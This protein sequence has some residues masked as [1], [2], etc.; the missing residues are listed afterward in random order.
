[1][2]KIF[3]MKRFIFIGA[4]CYLVFFA[5]LFHINNKLP[6]IASG[7][8][9]ALE[10]PSGR[11]SWE[12]NRIKDPATN[13][14]PEGIFVKELE[15]ASKLPSDRFEMKRSESWICRGPWHVGG[16][17][18]ALAYDIN[19]EN[20]LIAGAVSGGIWRS[21]NEGS[22][23][24]KITPLGGLQSVSCISQDKRAG[25]TNTWYYG[26]G[27]LYGNSA[28]SSYA[29]Y[30]G[31]GIYKSTDNGLSWHSLT[32]TA[33][34]TPTTFDIWDGVWNIAIDQSKDTQD[35]VYA[36]TY[37]TIFRSVDGG[38]SWKAVLGGISSAYSYFTDVAVTTK[39]VVYATLSYDGYN[40]GI[41]RSAD[42]LK[43]T[44]ITPDSFPPDY[45][46][47]VIGIDPN[48]E[49][50]VYFIAH[51]PDHGKMSQNYK[52]T[53]DWN[54][55]WKFTYISG[56]SST[57]KGSWQNLTNNIPS[58]GN[59][60]FDDFS[61]QGSYDLLV[62][63]KPGDS[64]TI[65]IG[66][67]NLYRSTDAF[68]TSANIVQIGGYEPATVL[69]EWHVYANH[70]PDQHVVQFFKSNPDV[71][72]SGNDGGIFKTSNCMAAIVSWQPLNHGYLT[73]Q[74]YTVNIDRFSNND[75]VVAGF[76]DN[77]NYFINDPDPTK[78]W[79][80]P[81]NGDGS[82]SGIAADRSYYIL[83]KQEG[84]MQKCS[85]DANGNKTAFA[86]IDPIGGYGYQFINPFIIDPNDDNLMYLAAGR[87]IFRNDKMRTIPLAGNYDSISY[88]WTMFT[89]S[90]KNIRE[91]TALA[92]SKNPANRLYFGTNSKDIYRIDQANTG[93]P[94]LI[95]LPSTYLPTGGNV[96]CI[97]VDPQNA[98]KVLVVYSNYNVYSLFYSTD[99]GN[100][101]QKT[102]GNLEEKSDGTGNGPS[103]RWVSVM[104]YGSKTLYLL[105][106]SV[107]L[108]ATDSL[109]GLNTT[110][111]QIGANSIGN[112]I[113]DMIVCR[114]TDGTIGLATHGSGIFTT[115][116]TSVDDFLGISDKQESKNGGIRIFPNPASSF[117]NI[118]VPQY[119]KTG[120]T[121]RILN[122]T[123]VEIGSYKS[124]SSKFTA[125]LSSYPAG[126]YNICIQAGTKKENLELIIVR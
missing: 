49:D 66:G 3:G 42:G 104:H 126:V 91:I 100:S 106:S 48:N 71:M 117:V 103:L 50:R 99:G 15:F 23:W 115:K 120:F 64:N 20:I 74:A 73:T 60:S 30:M 113:V 11:M 13:R 59:K 97:T 93:N 63:V 89:D 7:S 98:D 121:I 124:V 28:S 16:R 29:F 68:K 78:T 82:Y 33:S 95:K 8:E 116:I 4:L 40:K 53:K 67:T 12:F 114:E 85:L 110:W 61:A 57:L 111:K 9:E 86:R 38:T 1:M 47:I 46:R 96:S 5:L 52:G 22:S 34:N 17:T 62:V 112:A 105:G 75:I 2:F 94:A 92:V 43:W 24:S 81:L 26:T 108:F 84:K 72:L 58:K 88:G 69:P 122:L 55:L 39:G 41:W 45:K 32:A 118:E 21:V 54:S 107:G 36:A 80:M 44:E 6:I 25:K 119:S 65:I 10:N 70:H 90:I 56:D 14:I 76:Q 51:T 18:R 77:G 27:E 87:H 37:G 31:N 83:S 109:N 102:A 101:W 19:N 35:V 123:G 79:V 125:D